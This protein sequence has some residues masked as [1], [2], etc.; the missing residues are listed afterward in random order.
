MHRNW[1]DELFSKHSWLRACAF[2]SVAT[3]ILGVMAC[4]IWWIWP[5][6]LF[7]VRIAELTIGMVFRA[8]LSA[9]LVL[10]T[11]HFIIFRIINSEYSHQLKPTFI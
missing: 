11:L 9:F 1:L 6:G 2:F 3:L 10:K 4:V 5:T 8:L 7:D